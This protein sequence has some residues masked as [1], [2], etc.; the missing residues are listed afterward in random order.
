MTIGSGPTL[1]YNWPL[2]RVH[3][4]YEKNPLEAERIVWCKLV[5]CWLMDWP[6][7]HG[8]GD[9]SKILL[10]KLELH[11]IGSVF[12]GLIFVGWLRVLVVGGFW[13]FFLGGA[14]F[15]LGEIPN[16]KPTG[17]NWRVFHKKLFVCVFLWGGQ[18][19]TLFLF[20]KTGLIGDE[21]FAQCF[22]ACLPATSP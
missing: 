2:T 16:P 7:S 4:P 9:E 8:L 11:P 20:L 6:A 13:F 21:V 18:V 1:L 22:V 10:A 19:C 12:G 3:V 17:H 5:K 14:H 15:W